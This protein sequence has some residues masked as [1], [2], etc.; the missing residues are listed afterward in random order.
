MIRLINVRQ[1]LR[2]L[3]M[4][5]HVDLL[6]HITVVDYILVPKAASKW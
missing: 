4:N 2:N 5:N 3:G 1:H 6:G